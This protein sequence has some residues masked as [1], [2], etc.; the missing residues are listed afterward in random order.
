MKM[1]LLEV[2]QSILSSMNS[3]A[4][5]SINDTVEAQQVAEVVKQTYY[6]IISDR[7][8]P[9]LKATFQFPAD[10]DA[11]Y[12]THL[13]MPDD[14]TRVDVIKY[15]CRELVGDP[16]KMKEIILMEPEEFLTYVMARDSTLAEVD[17]VYADPDALVASTSIKLLIYNDRHPTYYT[18]FDD[19]YVIFDSYYSTLDS[20]IQKVKTACVGYKEPSWSGLDEQQIDLPGKSFQYLLTEAKS[21]AWTEIKETTN[22][23]A[24]QQSRRQRA[25]TAVNKWRQN[26]GI[27]FPI[28]WGR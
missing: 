25:W 18:S 19:E 4:V 28:N 6:E 5:D 27:K 21:V 9:H 7:E 17:T 23:K 24:E 12:P 13:R 20:T 2:V 11:S 22:A 10:A 3:D 26:G 1:T 15:D 14:F 8:W 16:I